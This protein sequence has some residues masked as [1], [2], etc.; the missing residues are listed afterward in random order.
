M[1]TT[2]CY[3]FLLFHSR[4]PKPK[5]NHQMATVEPGQYHHKIR[6]VW[7]RVVLL[8]LLRE[9]QMSIVVILIYTFLN[10][11]YSW[12]SRRYLQFLQSVMC[13]AFNLILWLSRSL[14]QTRSLI[15]RVLCKGQVSSCQF[16]W[17][18]VEALLQFLH[19]WV[20][21]FNTSCKKLGSMFLQKCFF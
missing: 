5:R 6:N 9:I 21:V 4:D 13:F 11:K 20:L 12:F 15:N 2:W 10:V 18:G 8:F 19:N 17:K 7:S 14:I 3:C 1:I 16:R